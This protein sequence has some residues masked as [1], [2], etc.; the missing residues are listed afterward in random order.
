MRRLTRLA[1]AVTLLLLPASI[2]TAGPF[3][4]TWIGYYSDAAM[5]NQVGFYYDDCLNNISSGGVQGPYRR[6]EI[7]SCSTVTT[8]TTCAYWNG[9]SWQSMACPW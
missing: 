3:T 6:R 9:S 4:E 5:T 8:S 1:F 2:T 7:T